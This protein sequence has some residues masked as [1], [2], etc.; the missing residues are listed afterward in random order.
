MWF[1]QFDDTP[2]KIPRNLV[3][4]YSIIVDNNCNI[5]VL[6]AKYHKYICAVG[7]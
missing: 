6:S 7:K 3:V 5:L 2:I 1:F 4:P